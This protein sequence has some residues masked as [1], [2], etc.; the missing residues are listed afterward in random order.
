[1]SR[2]DRRE[3]IFADEVDRQDLLKTVAEACQK[4]LDEHHARG[5]AARDRGG[6]GGTNR[7][8]GVAAAG[9]DGSGPG[10]AAQERSRK[11]GVG[12]AAATGNHADGQSGCGALAPRHLE[13]RTDA[14]ATAERQTKCESTANVLV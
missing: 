10:A 7:G 3:D 14:A 13:E 11:A 1:M 2:G 4:K 8:R 5:A 9:L 12:R 6:Q